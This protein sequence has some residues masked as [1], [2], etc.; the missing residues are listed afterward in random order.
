MKKIFLSAVF[1]FAAAGLFAKTTVIYHTSDTHGFYYPRNG[2]GGFAA[3]ANVLKNEPLPYLLLDSGDFSN[4]T[5]EAKNSKG[6]KSIALMNRLGYRATTLGNHE[7]DFKDAGVEP[8]LRAMNFPMLAANFLD[9]KTGRYPVNVKPFEIFDVDGVKI[10]VIGLANR[11]EAK[12][13][14]KYRF[15][16][17]L[18]VLEKSLEEIKTLKPDV[19]VVIVHD[20]IRDE[21]HGAERYMPEMGEKFGK[22]IHVILGGHAHVIVQNKYI[23]GVLYAECGLYGQNVTKITVETDDKT[24]RFVSAKSE[25][26]P[27]LIEEVGQDADTA[28]FAETLREPG[29]D[30]LV[31]EAAEKISRVSSESEHKDGPLNDWIADLGR[32]YAGTQIFV[33]NNGGSRIDMEKGTITKRDTMDIHPFDNKVVKMTVDGRFLKYLV[34]KSLLPRSRFTYSGMTITYRNKNGKVKDLKIFVDGKPI[35]NRQKYTLGTNDY[36]A[37]GNMEGWPFKRVKDDLKESVGT[38]GMRTLLEEGIQANSPLRPV[39]TGRI[40]EYK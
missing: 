40:V 32:A 14:K 36:I 1:L 10:A 35:Q 7:F 15:V 29:L 33:H 13:I 4:G 17:P 38:K 20:S 9:A 6:L 24:G 25:L 23:N 5:A 37:F 16:S 8:I 12:N 3:L 26:I 2:Q 30:V 22:D 11:S 28:A 21:R 19:V 18:P 39:S 31:G 27:L 34:K